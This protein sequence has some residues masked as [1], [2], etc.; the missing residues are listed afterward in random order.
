MKSGMIG[1]LGGLILGMIIGTAL[2][3]PLGGA[4]GIVLGAILG[5]FLV[6]PLSVWF[7]RETA[8][9]PLVVECPETKRDVTVTLEPGAAARAELW[10][11]RQKIETCSRFGGPPDC[12]EECVD[13]LEI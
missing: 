4:V 9:R 8:K 3:G 12:D 10:N 1:A 5:F 2:F 11:R 6:T 7:V 13:R